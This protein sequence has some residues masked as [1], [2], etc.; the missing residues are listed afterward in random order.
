[1]NGRHGGIA[2]LR[3]LLTDGPSESVATEC[4]RRRVADGDF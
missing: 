2:T 3:A 4:H 1:M